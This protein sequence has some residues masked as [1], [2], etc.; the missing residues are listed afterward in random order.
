MTTTTTTT[1]TL[2]YYSGHVALGCD[3]T[4]GKWDG[5]TFTAPDGSRWTV[6]PEDDTHPRSDDTG[7]H[8][9]I[10]APR[11]LRLASTPMIHSPGVIRWIMATIAPFDQPKAAELFEAMGLPTHDAAALAKNPNAARITYNDEDGTVTFTF[12]A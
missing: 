10:P 1:T 11:V 3:P 9:L 6:D 12:P 7:T 5:D 4:P 8:Q 2:P